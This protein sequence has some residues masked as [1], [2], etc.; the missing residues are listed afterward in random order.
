VTPMTRIFAVTFVTVLGSA[1]LAGAQA[2]A[3][4]QF[5]PLVHSAQIRVD[6]AILAPDTLTLRIRRAVGEA[7][8]TPTKVEVSA[9]G[10]S[11]PVTADSDGTWS[12]ALRGLGGKSPGR[13]DL[14]IDHDGIR[15]LLN[16]ALAAPAAGAGSAAAS[17]VRDHKQLAWWI[18][19]IGIVLIAALAISRRM[20]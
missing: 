8:L 17:L 10:R 9:L 16:G 12:V 7:A 4:V 20:S 19:N 2:P 3:N 18:L 14:V 1:R 13:L 15:E 11:L 5:E 6:A